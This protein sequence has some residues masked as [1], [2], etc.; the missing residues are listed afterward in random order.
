MNLLRIELSE[1]YQHIGLLLARVGFGLTILFGHGLGKVSRLF[2][3]EEIKFADPYGLGPA[4][5][6]GLATFAEVICSVLIIA[7]LFTRAA[8]IPLV[9]TMFTIVF[10]VNFDKGFGDIEKAALFGMAFLALFFTGPGKYSIDARLNK[11]NP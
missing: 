10:V 3:P 5:S 2:G 6:L 11:Q 8:L 9:F 1:R 4:F 7:G